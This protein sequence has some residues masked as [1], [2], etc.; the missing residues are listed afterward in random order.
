MMAVVQ[1]TRPKESETE[2]E[3][4]RWGGGGGGGGGRERVPR[5]QVSKTPF[6]PS[7]M[8]QSNRLFQ[9][10]FNCC[11]CSEYGYLRK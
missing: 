3:K 1:C 8:H 9:G 11:N 7:P 4:G 10:H 6:P 5:G 2:R